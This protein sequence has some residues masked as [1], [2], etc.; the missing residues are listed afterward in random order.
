MCLVRGLCPLDQRETQARYLFLR[1]CCFCQITP[2]R[3][4]LTMLEKFPYVLN[5]YQVL[6]SDLYAFCAI[7]FLI[8]VHVFVLLNKCAV[9]LLKSSMH[10]F[11]WLQ[12]MWR[13]LVCFLSLK[14]SPQNPVLV[15]LGDATWTIKLNKDSPKAFEQYTGRF[16]KQEVVG[17]IHRCID[18][19]DAKMP[20]YASWYKTVYR[21]TDEFWVPITIL[22]EY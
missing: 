1:I 2:L 9:L 3:L 21:D 5:T 14:S 15:V 19:R 18:Y 20:R 11:Q 8:V 7:S 17:S 10:I 16:T 4:V 22:S 13:L 12:L 6:S